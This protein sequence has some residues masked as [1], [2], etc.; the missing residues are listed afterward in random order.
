M[1]GPCMHT[2]NFDKHPKPCPFH[3]LTM[4]A[5]FGLYVLTNKHDGELCSMNVDA[6]HVPCVCLTTHNTSHRPH[7]QA[8]MLPH[9]R[10]T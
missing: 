1:N 9:A 4:R 5:L 2:H 10:T 8:V 3:A 7:T 6:A